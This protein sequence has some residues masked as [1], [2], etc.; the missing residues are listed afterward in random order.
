MAALI[1]AGAQFAPSPYAAYEIMTWLLGSLA[2]RSWDHVVL[3]APFILAGCGVLAFTGR[4]LDAL[5]LGEAQAESLGVNLA[6]RTYGA[7]RTAMAVGRGDLG[8]RRGRL[9]RPGRAASGAAVRRLSAQPHPAALGAGW[10][11]SCCW[12]PTSPRG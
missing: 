7:C 11:P 6:R 10:A 12:A 9:H 5:T 4:A 2:D 3:A 8:D 1:C